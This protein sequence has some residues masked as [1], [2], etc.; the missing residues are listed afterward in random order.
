MLCCCL[1]NLDYCCS[2][3]LATAEIEGGKYLDR[4]TTYVIGSLHELMT[5][6]ISQTSFSRNCCFK[7]A[8]IKENT[9]YKYAH[10]KYLFRY[11]S[12]DALVKA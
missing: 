2:N 9:L 11:R 5:R 6:S 10:T 7:V 4:S 8:Q 12:S 1:G 3:L